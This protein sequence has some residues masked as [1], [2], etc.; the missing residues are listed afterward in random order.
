MISPSFINSSD[1]NDVIFWTI[2]PRSPKIKSALL[3]WSLSIIFT[4]DLHL[5]CFQWFY[6]QIQQP[7][8]SQR[9]LLVTHVARKRRIL[10][11][12]Q[13]T[14][15]WTTN[16][17]CRFETVRTSNYLNFTFET[18]WTTDMKLF[19]LQIWN[20]SSYRFDTV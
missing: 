19:E 18:I 10:R 6:F 16:M 3:I 14:T 1:L 8:R 2:I 11:S 17:K 20:N 13:G 5:K 4:F 9:A 15:T 12:S 7:S